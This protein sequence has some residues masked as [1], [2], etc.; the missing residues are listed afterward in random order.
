MR[1]TTG[2]RGVRRWGV[3]AVAGLAAVLLAGCS[4]AQQAST[5]LPPTSAPAA[6]PAA[7]ASPTLPPLGPPDLPMPVEARQQTAVGA[8]AELRYYLAL[9]SRGPHAGDR[10][11]QDLSR[12][13]SFCSFL[14]NRLAKDSAAG[15]SYR[16]GAVTLDQLMPPA[17]HDSLAEFTFTASQAEVSVVDQAGNPVAGRGESA[18]PGLRGAAAM[19]WDEAGRA[20]LVTELSFTRP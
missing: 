9:I 6:A 10:S 14:A 13:C 17:I 4:G 18:A 8:T 19:Q 11:L 16:G 20:W 7:P 2:V 5:T 15:Y 12:D 1:T 3:G